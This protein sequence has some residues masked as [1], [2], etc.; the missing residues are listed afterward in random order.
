M[1]FLNSEGH[2]PRGYVSGQPPMHVSRHPGIPGYHPN[3]HVPHAPG[4][5]SLQPGVIGGIPRRRWQRAGVRNAT[6]EPTP[7]P[8]FAFLLARVRQAARAGV[9]PRVLVARTQPPMGIYH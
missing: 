7:P 4:S 2:K 9:G 3:I 1:A 5:M 8:V 6:P